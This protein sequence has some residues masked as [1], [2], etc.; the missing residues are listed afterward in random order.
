MR[1]ASPVEPARWPQKASLDPADVA[2]R[3]WGVIG[4]EQ[5]RHCGV[6]SRTVRRWSTGGKLHVIHRGVYAFGHASVPVEGRLVAALLHAGP[7]AVLSHA[8][9]AWWWKLI[10]EPPNCIEVSSPS[11]VRSTA[12]V[13]VHHPRHL[14]QTR[15]RRFPVTPISRTIVDFAATA[16]L[17]QVRLAL[18]EADYRRLL[19]VKALEGAMGQGRPGTALLRYALERHQPRLA[20]ASSPLEIRFLLLCE[21][22]GIPLPEVNARVAGWKVD[23]FWRRQRLVVELD[24]YGNHHTRAQIDR[25]RRKELHLRKAGFP[26]VRYSEQQIDEEQTAVVADVLARLAEAERASA[27]F[28]NLRPVWRLQTFG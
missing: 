11:R 12:G 18:A 5:L 21:S 24:G 14:E 23:A 28:A 26:V 27:P 16:S 3:Q 17:T 1:E 2:G 13:I 9:A 4:M 20:Q 19:D 10:P 7:G 6:S 8:T 22:A 15:H 25:D